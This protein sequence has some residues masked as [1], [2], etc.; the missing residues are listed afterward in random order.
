MTS[1]VTVDAESA[2]R[3]Y[4]TLIRDPGQLIDRGKVNALK[5]KIELTHDPVERL[6]LRAELETV[7]QVD[8][9]A[10]ADRFVA[11]V[12]NWANERGITAQALIAEG[13]EESLLRRA[14]LTLSTDR[15]R[16]PSTSGREEPSRVS[17]NM[18]AVAI[19]AMGTFT[20]P[21][22]AARTGGSQGTVRKVIANEISAGRVKEI[23]TDSAH[24][25]LGRA[26]TL[27]ERA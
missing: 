5:R 1:T 10:I 21:Q 17:A 2:I 4:L 9:T 11:Y 13:A 22:L 18:I 3:D 14:G 24:N 26:P 16:R 12:K 8:R 20:I 15:P 6:T 25:G 19:P 7:G 27:Y 23:G